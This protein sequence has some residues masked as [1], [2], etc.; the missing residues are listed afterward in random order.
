MWLPPTQTHAHIS[1]TERERERKRCWTHTSLYRIEHLTVYRIFVGDLPYVLP[2]CS[3]A[4]FPSLIRCIV[5]VNGPSLNRN[6]MVF[7]NFN[8]IELF[9]FIPVILYFVILGY[10]RKY[11]FKKIE[12]SK[13]NFIHTY[14]KKWR[15]VHDFSPC[16][17]V[18]KWI[19]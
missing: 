14:E 2:Y 3:T 16:Q 4:Q 6:Y 17:P 18:T 8:E 11:Y 1:T 13:R 15:Q 10:C 5:V 12:L 7:C 9:V 19:Q